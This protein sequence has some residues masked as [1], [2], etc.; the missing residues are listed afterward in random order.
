M[1]VPALLVVAALGL[2]IAWLGDVPAQPLQWLALAATSLLA[3]F[4]LLLRRMHALGLALGLA[5]WM[6]LGALGA[7]LERAAVPAYHVTRLLAAETLPLREPLRWRGRLRSDPA[8]LPWGLRQE[9]DLEEVEVAGRA[10]RLTGGLR[11]GYFPNERTPEEF[12]ALRAGDRV[13]ILVR[14]RAVRN[15]ANPGAFDAQ[16]HLARQG[17]HLTGTLRSTELLRKL[18]GAPLTLR[19]RLARIRGRLLELADAMFG[20]SPEHAAVLRAM[21]LGDRAFVD[22]ELAEAF[23]KTSAYHVLVISGLHVA[24]LAAFLVGCGRWL[25]V[26]PGLTTWLTLAVLAAFVGVV[27]DRPPILRA[28]CMAGVYLFSRLL[29]RRVDLLNTLAVAALAILMARPTALA[30]ASFQLSF[31]AAAM[32]GALGLPWVERSSGPYRAALA[33]LGDVTHD[34][35]HPPR[36][37]QFRL[38]LRGVAQSLAARL[39]PRLAARAAGWVAAA[40]GGGLRL[41]EVLLVSAAIQVG[42]LP[43]MAYYFHRV[44]PV[45]LLAN[46]PAVVLSALLVPLGYLTLLLGAV[47]PWMGSVLA[48]GVEGLTAALV[49]SVRWFSAWRGNSY[50]VPGPPE[51]V[52]VGFFV[53][54]VLLGAAARTKRGRWQVGAAILVTGLGFVLAT[55]PF[56]PRLATGR[57]E[58]T[59]LDVGQGDAILVAFPDGRT[60]LVDG[61]G[62]YGATRVGGMRI[63]LDVG[64]QVVSSYLWSRGLKR[65]DAVALTHAH[66]DHLDG[67]H[68]VLDNFRVGELWLGREVDTP[69]F[70]ALVGHAEARGTR[71]VYQR[72][73]ARFVWGGVTGLVLWP[74]ADGEASA[75]SNNDSLVLRLDHGRLGFLLPGDIERGVEQELVARGDP[76]DV[77]FLKVPH[78]G[79]RTSTTSALVH[80]ATPAVTVISVGEANPFGHPHDEMLERV[81]TRGLRL[82]RTDRDGATTLVSDGIALRVRTFA[83]QPQD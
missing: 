3:G 39:S 15:F 44:A 25:R 34:A 62:S 8:R 37:A 1:K 83:Q 36:A 9:V 31:L 4:G 77:D 35:A 5:A 53:A 55:H 56:A 24:A 79:S 52:L 72:R 22:H 47:W 73:G 64:E 6:F 43:A 12:P 60:L 65:L 51:W 28:A 19:H 70:R 21:L 58:L 48:R 17:I 82:A 32:I 2:G 38:D 13:E 27:E 66:Q 26:S 45:G 69:S 11:V 50:R 33:H 80:A 30:D 42:M 78:H 63:G 29:F 41:W 10:L 59:V 7:A 49:E 16:S 81:R 23:Q 71:V 68:A 18:D 75:A 14:A 54:L 76:L 61:G 67:L 74:E 57:L 40:V 46:V 20:R